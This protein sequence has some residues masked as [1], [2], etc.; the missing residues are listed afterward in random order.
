MFGLLYGGE[1]SLAELETFV[2]QINPATREDDLELVRELVDGRAVSLGIGLVG[3]AWAAMSIHGALE[4]AVAGVLGRKSRRAF[5]R[6]KVDAL[7]FVGGLGVLAVLSFAASYGL[8]LI[9]DLA[10]Q[11]AVPAVVGLLALVAPVI[12]L[13]PGLA[14][15]YGVFR[16]I[17]NPRPSRAT[18]LRGALVSAVLWEIAK[19]AFALLT[20]ALGTFE[21]YGAIAFAA[22]L[23]TWIYVSAAILLVG[24][25]V[26]KTERTPA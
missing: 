6:G 2:R 11:L 21:V 9:A 13:L 20:R 15:F 10:G 5:V 12:G 19:L 8:Q 17:P 24:A 7:L 26:I 22:G 23:L 25:E 16:F 3:T 4:T 14:L 18:A 1:R